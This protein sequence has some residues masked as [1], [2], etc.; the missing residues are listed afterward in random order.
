MN[1]MRVSDAI[2]Q[3]EIIHD[4]LAKAEEYRGFH[5]VGVALSGLVGFVAAFAQPWFVSPDAPWAFIRYWL[6]TATIAIV[7]GTMAPLWAYL[8]AEDRW[9]RMR[10]RRVASQFMPCLAAGLATT[11]AFS[12]LSLVELLP[13]L[14]TTLF[15]LGLFAARPYLPR[16]IGWVG[17]FYLAIGAELLLA[18]PIELSQMG[19]CVGISFAAGQAATAWV[20][21]RNKERDDNA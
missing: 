2:G 20:L 18:P 15:G 8:W 17:L 14:W 6:T 13:G 11:F 7:A 1:N 21:R 9:A 19:L 4:Q 5:P 3:I 16:S 10:S 12:R